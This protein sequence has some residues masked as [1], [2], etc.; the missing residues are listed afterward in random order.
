MPRSKVVE[1]ARV[2]H[3]YADRDA[4]VSMPAGASFVVPLL[5]LRA[6]YQP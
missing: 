1:P 2:A 5:R 6:A 4:C 3:S